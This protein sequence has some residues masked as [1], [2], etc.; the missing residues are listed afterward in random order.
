M[1][2]IRDKVENGDNKM[3]IE[4]PINNSSNQLIASGATN[5]SNNTN[6]TNNSLDSNN[7][8]INNNNIFIYYP[9]DNFNLNLQN[10]NESND[11]K[12]FF[13]FKFASNGEYISYAGEYLEEI[14]ANLIFDEKNLNFKPNF[15][16]MN[17][18]KDINEQM[19]AILIDWLIEVHYR[20]NLKN[21][22]LFQ[23]IW[24][25]D[26]YLSYKQISRAKLQLLGIASL[27]IS[28]KSQEIYFPQ[29]KD[30]I[31]ITDGAYKKEELIT[32]ENNIL[33]ILK[34]NIVSPTSNDFYNILSKAFNFDKT[35]FYFG[36]YFLES[37]LI[38]YQMIKYKPSLIAV[39]CVYIVM[40][41]FKIS[42]YKI[43]YTNDVFREECPQ[44]A[45]KNTARAIYFL[46]KNLS[47]LSLKAAKDKYS[48]SQFLNVT[49]YIEQ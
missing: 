31:D 39:S 13:N 47:H 1:I 23:T 20:F 44:T 18:Q 41:I 15:G 28:C 10:S 17:Q 21:E 43:L 12:S 6:N 46:V 16:Y 32:M 26:T 45:I 8:I 48:L 30:F 27:L 40:K 49:Q 9:D 25:I 29:L 4:I 14:Y 5:Y 11:S 24:I 34:F 7:I 22:T 19:R 38:D 37:A 33:K 35:Q 3:E 36:R 2:N 42:D